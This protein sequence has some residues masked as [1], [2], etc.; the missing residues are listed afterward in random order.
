M[1]V[2]SRT[3]SIGSVTDRSA[4]EPFNPKDAAAIE[5][6]P[7]RTRDRQAEQGMIALIDEAKKRGDSLGGVFEVIVTGVP[8]GLG[9]HVHYDR[10]LDGRLAQAIM[11]INAV[12][13][14]ELGL[15]FEGARRFGS[16]VHDEIFFAKPRGFF[17]KTNRAGGTEGGMTTGEPLV[18]RVALK[19]IS[20]LYKP[21][22]SVDLVTKKPF[23]A[24]VERSDICSVPA[25]EIIGEAVVAFELAR[26]ALE[27]F[28]GDSLREFTRNRSGYLRQVASL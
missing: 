19:P 23:L 21:L 12:K 1:R 6:S 20:T 9:S 5:A 22:R 28:G 3:V 13:G 17:R 26:A 2:Y 25:A 18:V 10:K 24:S 27:K 11:S 8:P 7:T 15:G 16:Q 4:H 14:V